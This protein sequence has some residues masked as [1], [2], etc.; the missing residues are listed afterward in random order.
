MASTLPTKD[1]LATLA[2]QYRVPVPINQRQQKC[3]LLL[4]EIWE[5]KNNANQTDYTVPGGLLQLYQDAVTATN[6][7]TLDQVQAALVG[8]AWAVAGAI[9]GAPTTLNAQLSALGLMINRPDDA[10]DRMYILI[11]YLKMQS[12]GD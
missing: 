5:L 4:A 10:L 1:T 3:L 9:A 11:R 12:S 8:E 6:G 7:M 2:T